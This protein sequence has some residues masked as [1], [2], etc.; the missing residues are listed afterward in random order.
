[1]AVA[2]GGQL[3]VKLRTQNLL[4]R[5]PIPLGK[6]VFGKPMR[7]DNGDCVLRLGIGRLR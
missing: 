3:G 6:Q 1:M 5:K 4:G 2:N 7:V